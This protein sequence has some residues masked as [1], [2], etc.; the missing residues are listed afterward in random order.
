MSRLSAWFPWLPLRGFT[1]T[2]TIR[3][4]SV[5]SGQVLD[6]VLSAFHNPSNIFFIS[7]MK[8]LRHRGGKSPAQG[9]T[10][11][12]E[13]EVGHED[14]QSGPEPKLLTPAPT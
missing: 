2:V 7:F 5:S 13:A 9:Y 1:G 14:G 4:N 12:E 11:R 3:W 10:G 8:K 6:T